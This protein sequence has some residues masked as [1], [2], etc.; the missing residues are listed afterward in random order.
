MFF[1]KFVVLEDC[2]KKGIKEK[3]IIEIIKIEAR[4]SINVIPFCEEK[5]VEKC[6]Y[7]RPLKIIDSNPVVFVIFNE[8]F[9]FLV[10]IVRVY[11]TV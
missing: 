4:I 11:C 5:M 2:M 7:T 1:D 8:E 6:I 9:Y 3:I 10:E